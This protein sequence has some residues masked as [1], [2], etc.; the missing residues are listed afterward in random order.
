MEG[1]IQ[2]TLNTG[3]FHIDFIPLGIFGFVLSYYFF[4]CVLFWF[5]SHH[6]ILPECSGWTLENASHVP[7]IIPRI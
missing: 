4:C 1:D 5:F 2:G 6:G 7:K 3:D